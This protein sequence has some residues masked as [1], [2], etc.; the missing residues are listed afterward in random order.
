MLN[1]IEGALRRDATAAVSGLSGDYTSLAAIGIRTNADGTLAVDSTKL[2]KAID[3]DAA[4]VGN[5]FG[6]ANGVAKRLSDKTEK[7]LASDGQFATRNAT[8]DKR[9]KDADKQIKELDLRM[10]QIEARYRRQFTALDSMLANLQTQSAFL[11]QQ[12][13]SLPSAQ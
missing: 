5:I 11:A 2:Q 6:S 12:L 1:S 8:L 4:A 9:S 10:T 13:A 7:W 3:A